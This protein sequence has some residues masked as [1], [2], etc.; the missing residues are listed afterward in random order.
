M[1]RIRGRNVV[2]VTFRGFF[3]GL[4]RGPGHDT[5]PTRRDGGTELRDRKELFNNRKINYL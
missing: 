3:F 2:V 4:V 5:P 1:A